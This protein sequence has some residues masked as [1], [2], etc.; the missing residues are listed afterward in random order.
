MTSEAI[1]NYY[2]RE[3]ETKL[4]ENPELARGLGMVNFIEMYADARVME[5][6]I[7]HGLYGV[8]T[9]LHA[10]TYIHSSKDAIF[11]LA[12]EIQLQGETSFPKDL[13]SDC[14][15]LYGGGFSV[16]PPSNRRKRWGVLSI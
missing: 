4:I 2:I 8:F 10:N 11:S 6:Q 9:L 12:D 13:V 16:P 14:L 5:F 15:V 3:A 1:R 7:I